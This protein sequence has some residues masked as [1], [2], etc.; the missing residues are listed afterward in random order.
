M[1]TAAGF[2]ALS[3]TA[4]G[5]ALVPWHGSATA[6]DVWPKGRR[7]SH[8]EKFPLASALLHECICGNTTTWSRPVARDFTRRLDPS[9][10]GVR[11]TAR[12]GGDCR[13]PLLFNV[14]VRG[15]WWWFAH[16]AS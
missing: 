7:L 8:L 1:N 16:H 12:P 3:P 13:L 5:C 6:L 2:S 9:G 10:I 14:Q 15:A 4:T 11:G